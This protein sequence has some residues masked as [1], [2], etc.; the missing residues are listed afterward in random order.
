MTEV[1]ASKELFKLEVMKE[2]GGNIGNVFLLVSL[3][4]MRAR[5][6]L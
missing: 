6:A 5:E 4:A 2:Q 1:R 3:Q